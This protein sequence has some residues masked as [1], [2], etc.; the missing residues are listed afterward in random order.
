MENNKLVQT[1]NNDI[2][3]VPAKGNESIVLFSLNLLLSLTEKM[4]KSM[5]I[6]L[7]NEVSTI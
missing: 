3:V 5:Y 4:N 1:L 6:I 7:K 2:K